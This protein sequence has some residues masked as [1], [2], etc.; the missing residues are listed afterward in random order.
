MRF[1]HFFHDTLKLFVRSKEILVNFV[2]LLSQFYY[3]SVRLVDELSGDGQSLLPSLNATDNLLDISVDFLVHLLPLF[4][5][6]HL[7]LG[8]IL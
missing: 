4:Y 2:N 7:H 1:S 6:R 3:F 8:G 5:L